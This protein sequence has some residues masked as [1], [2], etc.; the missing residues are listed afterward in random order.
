[1]PVSVMVVYAAL[2]V[3]VVCFGI[4]LRSAAWRPF[5]YFGLALM[6]YLN[7]EKTRFSDRPSSRPTAR[8]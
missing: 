1:M 6:L 8:C 5:L 3:W 7:I 2:V 4:G